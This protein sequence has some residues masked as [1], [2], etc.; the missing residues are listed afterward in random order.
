MQGFEGS[1]SP[2]SADLAQAVPVEAL[3][4]VHPVGEQK[5]AEL[6]GDGALVGLLGHPL[7]CLAVLVLQIH[8]QLHLT[9]Q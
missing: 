4:A 7:R 9:G 2:T 1:Q 5:V 6:L 3:I 8:P